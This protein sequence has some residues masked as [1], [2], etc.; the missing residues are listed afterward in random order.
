LIDSVVKGRYAKPK[1]LLRRRRELPWGITRLRDRVQK[2][3]GRKGRR[4]DS[5]LYIFYSPGGPTFMVVIP[6]ESFKAG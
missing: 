1:V 4:E 2:D 3:R 6:H 5:R